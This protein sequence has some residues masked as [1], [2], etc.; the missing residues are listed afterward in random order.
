[1]VQKRSF[2]NFEIDN[3]NIFKQKLLIWSNN[4][5]RLAFLDSNNSINSNITY[6][7]YDSIVAVGCI[8]EI[9]SE[10]KYAFS[11]LNK[12]HSKT[13]DW[14]FG[15]LTYDLKNNIENLKSN[16]FDGIKLP[17]LNF[18]VPQYIFIINK[19]NLKIACFSDCYKVFN[20]I[21]NIV[22]DKSVEKNNMIIKSMFSN[23]EYIESVKK[24]KKHILKGDIY[25]ANF[26]MEFYSKNT[27]IN[28]IKTYQRLNKI[29]P[30]PFSCYYKF[31]NTYLISA[32]PERFLKKSSNKI[33]SQPIKGTIKRGKNIKEDIILKNKLQN[34]E[35]ERAENIMI[36]DLVRNDL[37][38]LAKKAS[39]KVEELCEIY[40]F[41]QVHQMISTVSSLVNKNTNIIDIIKSTFP[42]GSMTGAPKISAMKIIEEYEK[43]KRGLYS[44]SVGY[45]SPD[46]NFDFN[47]IIRS[48][49]YNSSKKYLSFIVGSAITYKSNAENEFEECLIKAEAIKKALNIESLF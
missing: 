49:L 30:T 19:N 27:N 17:A 34:N 23:L 2:Y 10:T 32:S 7:S 41:S 5:D 43:T 12:F 6:A 47:V 20:E 36:V 11:N 21:N 48:I 3:I 28:P 45:I 25:E 4:F 15:F 31:N 37:S 26:C 13:N 35:K 1:M 29:S 40:S 44:G 42:M 9:I 38:I 46:G 39:V 24:I 8:N 14:I 16:N 18:F 22:L 33:I